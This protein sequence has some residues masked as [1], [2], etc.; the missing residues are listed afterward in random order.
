VLGTIAILIM[1]FMPKGVWGE[2]ERRWGIRLF[3][4]QRVLSRISRGKGVDASE[5][6]RVTI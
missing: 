4:T 2:I 6:A 1:L 5:D 3:P